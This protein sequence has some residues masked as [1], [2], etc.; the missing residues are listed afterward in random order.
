MFERFTE[1]ARQAV[2]RA[3][4]AAREL[5]HGYIGTEHLLLGLLA[6]GAETP[7]QVLGPLGINYERIHAEILGRVGRGEE[8]PT[9]AQIPFRPQAKTCLELGLR[10]T[11]TLRHRMIRPGHLLLGLL[12]VEDGLAYRVL[13]DLDVSPPALREVVLERLGGPDPEGQPERRTARVVTADVR[14]TVGPDPQLVR[15]MRAAGGRAMREERDEFGLAD[16][17]AIVRETPEAR[18]LLDAEDR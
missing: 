12:R 18:R 13:V 4:D 16:L 2:V 15:L 17:L 9:G 5:D 6:D 11:L 3:Q 10:E 7:A 1:G 14:F 8:P